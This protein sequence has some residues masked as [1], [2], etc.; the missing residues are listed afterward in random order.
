MGPKNYKILDKAY[1]LI[2]FYAK[3][4]KEKFKIALL[5]TEDWETIFQSKVVNS[6]SEQYARELMK[7]LFKPKFY[8]N[9]LHCLLDHGWDLDSARAFVIF[10]TEPD[11]KLDDSSKQNVLEIRKMLNQRIRYYENETYPTGTDLLAMLRDGGAISIHLITNYIK[12][13]EGKLDNIHVRR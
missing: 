6:L 1:N 3:Q 4:F 5:T 13:L 7:E 12:T 10:V 11:N 2:T 8:V 9:I